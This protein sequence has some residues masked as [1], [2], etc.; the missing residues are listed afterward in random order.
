LQRNGNNIGH[1]W[2][3]FIHP[4]ILAHLS[5]TLNLDWKNNFFQF[6]I[7]KKYISLT[8]IDWNIVK[9]NWP[10]STKSELSNEVMH[11]VK[12]NGKKGVPLYQNIAE[13]WNWRKNF[14]Q[15]IIEKKY[16]SV[17]D[18]DWDVVKESWP[19]IPK[20]NFFKATNGFVQAHGKN[21]VPLYQ[22]ISENMHHM[23]N[24]KKVSQLQL[25]L[26]NEFEKLRNKN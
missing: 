4:T 11:F 5:G 1:S 24:S 3:G 20:S 6:I 16:I 9:E 23:K 10:S 15:F 7:D 26:I 18:I 13:N 17:T 12:N 25:D 2:S 22:N 21:G 14:F 8:D 19:S